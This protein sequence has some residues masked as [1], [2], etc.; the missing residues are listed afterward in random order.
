VLGEDEGK[1]LVEALGDKGRVM[2]LQNH[3]LLTTGGTVD[4]AAYLFTALERTCEV[5]LMV[6]AA[7]L[8]KKTASDEAAEF[9]HKVNADPVS[10]LPVLEEKVTFGEFIQPNDMP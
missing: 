10:L 1:K 6:E 5:Q 8:E 9:T 7:G 2:L 4:E 3:G